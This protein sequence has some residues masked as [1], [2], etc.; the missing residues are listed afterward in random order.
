M[1][2][3][4]RILYAQLLVFITIGAFSQT[5]IY[6][7][8]GGTSQWI[9]PVGVTSVTLQMWGGGGA[10]D[11]SYSG[12]GGAFV[13]TTAIPV[14]AGQTYN[15]YVA[16]YVAPYT[17]DVLIS[18]FGTVDTV[19][20]AAN[21]AT[22]YCSDMYGCGFPF[23]GVASSGG[24]VAASYGGGGGQVG[25]DDNG[26]PIPSGG[27]AAGSSCGPG[28]YGQPFSP[29]IGQCGAGSGGAGSTTGQASPGGFPG[30]GGGNGIGNTVLGGIG[31]IILTYTC[32]AGTTGTIGNAH[33][34]TY[35]PELTPDN[36]TS[37]VDPVL[38]IGPVI[39]WQQ[40]TDN[41]NF[42]TAKNN[43]NTPAYRFDVDSIQTI[44]YYRRGNNA[45]VIGGGFGNWSDT[46]QIKVMNSANGR[47][48]K[49]TGNVVSRNGTNILGRKV[50]AQSLTPLKG[51]AVGFLDSTLTDS[52]GRFSIDSI[53]YGDKDNGDSASVRFKVFPDTAGNH[54]YDNPQNAFITLSA[55]S[56]NN[57]YNLST[58]FRDTSLY[59]ITGQVYQVC[60]GCLNNKN[61]P[62]TI[63]GA[64][65]S[66]KVVGIGINQHGKDS[67]ITGYRIPPGTYGN[68]GLLFQNA[69]D[70]YTVTPKFLNHTFK[71]V[72]SVVTLSSNVSNVNFQDITTHVISGFFGAGCSD[73]IGKAVLEFDDTL[74]KG[75]NGKSRSSIFKMRV[76]TNANGHYSIRLP[77]RAYKVKIISVAVSDPYDAS[78][79]EAIIKSFFN[80]LPVDSVYRNIY[81]HDTTMNLVYQRPPQMQVSGLL[82]SSIIQNCS[83]FQKFAIWPQEEVRPVTFNI[84]QGP[85]SRSCPL[86]KGTVYLTT[87]VSNMMGK[88][89][90]DT[91][92]IV[93]GKGILHL[94]AAQPN[95]LKNADSN[96]AKYFSAKYTDP[97]G[98]SISSDS[99]N[100]AL[101]IIVVTGV[102]ID[103]TAKTFL[104]VTPQ[105]PLL[106]LHDPPG[107]QSFS[108]YSK[109]VSSE[110]AISF[111]TESTL[112]TGGWIDVKLGLDVILGVFLEEEDK[113]WGDIKASVDIT[114]TTNN[115]KESVIETTSTNDFSTSEDPGYVGPDDDLFYG[116]AMNM[117]YSE[118]TEIDW[119]SLNCVF[120]RKKVPVFAPEGIQTSFVYTLAEIRD[121]QI[122]K[123]QLAA[124]AKPDSA[125]FFNNQIK[126]WQQLLENNDLNKQKAAI[127][128]NLSFSSGNSFSS[129]TTGSTTNTNTYEY[130]MEIDSKLATEVGFEIA[131][132]GLS[133]GFDVG[134]KMTTG[135]SSTTTNTVETTTG[136]TLKDNN[137]GGL[138]TVNIKKDPVYG[139]PMFETIAGES[140]CP[141]EEGTVALDN[142]VLTAKT[143]SL[144]NVKSDTANFTL[145]LGNL[146]IDPN[147]RAYLLF[148]NASS[149]PNGATVLIGGTSNP[150]GVTY[151]IPNGGNQQVTIS[152]IRNS[153]SGVFNYDNLEF[154]LSD[155]CFPPTVQQFLL[156]PHQQSRIL[157]SAD[158][159]SPVSGVNLVTP[160]SNWIANQASN[161]AVSVT[162]NGYDTSKLVSIA[163]QYNVPGTGTWTTAFTVLKNKLGN[164]ITG[165]TKSWNI[166]NIADGP[167]N[168]RLMVIDKNN[169]IVYSSVV[170]GAIERTPPA[171]FGIPRPSDGIYRTGTQISYKY[172]E[173]I[174]NTN[175]RD[176]MVH[177]KDLTT[178]T[179]IPVQL[180]GF[181]NRLIILPAINIAPLVGHLFRVI[182]DSVADLYG[183]V[184]TTP[185]TS[186]FN[187]ATTIFSTGSDAL[188]ITIGKSSMY[189]DAKG[190][191][192][193]HFTRN[194]PVTAPTVVYYSL[195]G[196]A[197]YNED[198][199][200]TYSGGQTSVT[201]IDG[202]EGAILI[203]KDS[204]SAV[205]YIHPV[206][207]TLLSADKRIIITSSP[208][209]GYGI[210]S[211]YTVTAT[212][213]NHNLA[214]PV[215]TA[216]GPTTFCTG[217]SVILRT[218]NKINGKPV[219]ILW[220]T[221]ATA[222]SIKVK[223]SGSYTVK[224]TDKKGF[225]GYSAP[226]VVTVTCGSPAGLT[227]TVLNN[228]STK[229]TWTIVSCA[230]K[231]L[232]K[233]REVGKPAW[234]TDT[235]NSN[236]DTLKGLKAN[237]S[238]QWQVAS[239][240][241]YP[242]IIM[243]GYTAGSNFTTPVSPSEISVTNTS[244]YT[245]AS[246]GDGFSASIYPNPAST[247]AN[248]TVKDVKGPYSVIVTNLQGVVLWKVEKVTD[249]SVK[250]PLGSFA[251]GIYMITVKDQLHM[252][253]LKLMK[254]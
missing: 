33:T 194:T 148:L 179:A 35:T 75:Y 190:T 56:G 84:Y 241:Q 139:T 161:N 233:Y 96:Y 236:R 85:I 193:I 201:G 147:P 154:I 106:I 169:N 136:Y 135:Q 15:V 244:D 170:T 226:T 189:E 110:Q 83:A 68:Y 158:F 253:T 8:N 13:Q 237:T 221:G 202:E 164:A 219:T 2:Q 168:L 167:Y 163:L 29:G 140:S 101:P 5:N 200:V 175:L 217:D 205:M 52:Q 18:K 199:A 12:G 251:Q 127:D 229:L 78:T 208:G 61:K 21:G 126:V 4:L 59:A 49:I 46:V 211:N 230:K 20:V 153:S 198:Y 185:D 111:Q 156:Y 183:N 23:G 182:V 113:F 105:V 107:A 196:N 103:T 50:Y 9:C 91:I 31:R 160:T 55:L 69:N 131:G 45:C 207:D 133:G 206:G 247:I 100:P 116:A 146:S 90:K 65:D 125:D 16:N 43:T 73:V 87:D 218:K 235:V 41:I 215:I 93:N 74:P 145:Y 118:G 149:N 134:F 123:L 63:T 57:I 155:P 171:L 232:V 3:F 234:T 223:T 162:F 80:T 157:L 24:Y 51:R 92:S 222:D 180:S 210:G 66:V 32:N 47:N 40:S 238:Y 14:T 81:S 99:L 227:A 108:T 42:V 204:S 72:D 128:S 159:A 26:N 6:F 120:S 76:T 37:I 181:S 88:Y 195:A 30:G 44:T 22:S 252:G 36:I 115:T 212:I 225:T 104:T 25:H 10:G 17:N 1:K 60:I 144:S 117:K 124:Q 19:Y 132:T 121:Q 173:V 220:S 48:G 184:K 166:K 137:T 172:T 213:L 248:V 53:F 231:Y 245:K 89:D 186:F 130:T 224:V 67:S 11:G 178:N 138:F 97:L 62:D 39:A 82:D 151:F 94:L 249:G 197:E 191:M 98:R 214:A 114:N 71:P 152:V 129:T 174:D 77:A 254:Q 150:D 216:S 70:N 250:I 203:P 109:S 79:N 54:K 192:D 86:N 34:I 165:T 27:A 38:P 112:S 177:F 119:D 239:I 243:S 7:D 64:L 209:G 122:P 141:H 58:P 102:A 187:V 240:C 143:Q 176:S 242:V 246:A 28:A 228:N 188:N 95:P 142:T